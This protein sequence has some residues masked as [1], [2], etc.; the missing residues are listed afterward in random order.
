MHTNIN[1]YAIPMSL[2]TLSSNIG[3]T[4]KVEFQFNDKWSVSP[5][6]NLKEF[7]LKLFFS[8]YSSR[9]YFGKRIDW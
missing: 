5:G 3:L 8:N 4:K 2:Y 9:N 6:I 1:D 7:W